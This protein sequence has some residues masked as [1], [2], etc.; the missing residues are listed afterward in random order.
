VKSLPKVDVVIVGGGWAGL[1][2]AKELGA[3]TS[4]SVLVLERGKQR[5]A[6]D[7]AYGMDELDYAIRLRM[8]QDAS[9][10]TVTL[11]HTVKD[12]ALPM[13][14][15]AAFLPGDGTGGA[16]E[17]WNGLSFRFP[18]D[19]FEI[20]SRTVARYGAAKLPADS[21]ILD[22]AMTYGELEPH[23]TR[24]EQLLGVSGDASGDP[25][26]PPRSAPYP[27]PPMTL[28]QFSESAAVAAKSLGYHPA[29][30]PSANITR[31]YKNPDGVVR[32]PCQYCGYC[33]RF[34]CMV[35]AKSQPTNT[36]LPV[37]ARQ[38]NVV[39]RHG[40]NVRRV[41][42]KDGMATGVTYVSGQGEEVFQPA[43]IV[44][45]ASWTIN[46]T[47]LLL[48]S[49]LGRPYDPESGKGVVGRNFTH[50]VNTG[51]GLFFRKPLNR[52]MGAGSAGVAISDFDA[53]YFDHSNLNF[54]RGGMIVALNTGNRPI[55]GFGATPP[56][57]TRDWG[58]EWKRKAIE[59]F[60]RTARLACSAEHIA[61]RG[62]YLDLDPRYTDSLGDPLVRMTIDW[63]END[64]RMTEFIT[65]K[66]LE[67]G[68]TMDVEHAVAPTR[69]RHYSANSYQTTH[70]QGGT[71]AG[72]SP[73]TSVVNKYSQH[74][75][76]RNVFVLG[77]SG[78]PQN[79]SVNPTLTVLATT[80]LAA[81]AVVE[82]FVR[83]PGRLA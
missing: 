4:L 37:I 27:T 70:L 83:R 29:P 32:P 7:S 56:G 72:A 16:G 5:K 35:G 67:I 68:R 26:A 53:D 57:V 78:F 65:S 31:L 79:A 61:Y 15:F 42:H 6:T 51:I 17:H 77:A 41:V 18:P 62:N 58:S 63:H 81:D 22:W 50:Q 66:L 11:R 2:M 33:E 39:I 30:C 3:R 64:H 75:D 74:W 9:K 28:P 45:L 40:A 47:R 21:C 19:C 10:E 24:A 25:F 43:D 55:S 54:I 20:R 34:G 60:D 46:N 59:Y 36:L 44:M 48:L 12:H 69:G 82:R 80:L 71:I 52:F 13:R 38:K 76:A 23:Y 1:L 73:E 49:S 14:Q 8:M